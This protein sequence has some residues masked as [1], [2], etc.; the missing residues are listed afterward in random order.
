MLISP[1]YAQAAGG[2]GESGLITLL[3]IVL[4]FVV[5]YFLLIRPQQK[6]M[7]QHKAMV[8]A[9]RRGDKVVTGGGLI[10]TVAKVINDNEIQVELADNVKVRVLRHTIQDVMSKTEPAQGTAKG[11]KGAEEKEAANDDAGDSKD[12]S[13]TV[14]RGGG[15]SKLFGVGKEK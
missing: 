14:A 2:G 5:F 10:G 9:L 15:L 7:K 6:K 3:P 11:K 8:E 13:K 4:I 1:A 12:E